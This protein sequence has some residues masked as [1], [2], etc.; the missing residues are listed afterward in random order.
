MPTSDRSLSRPA[1]VILVSSV[2]FTFISYWRTAAVVLCDL[3]STAYYIGGIVEQSIGQAAPWFILAVMCFSYAV[4]WVYIESCTLFVRGGVSRVVREALGPFASKIAVSVLTFD[5]VLT[6]PISGVSAG[7][8]VIGLGIAAVEYLRGGPL[9]A[10]TAAAWK[11]L[12]P[13]LIACAVTLYFYRQNLRGIRESSGK[14]LKI[15]AVTTVMGVLILSWCGITLAYRAAYPTE[16]APAPHLPTVAPRLTPRQNPATG[17]EEDPLGVLR[18]T[19]LADEVRSVGEQDG[20]SWLSLVGLFGVAI[21]FGH[22]ILAMSGEEVLAQVYREVE[23]PKLRNFKKAAFLVFVYSL[24]FTGLISFLAVMIIPD[25]DRVS[26]YGDNLI[27]GLAMNVV[28]WVPLRLALN[29]FVVG[30]GFLIL[31]GAVN[32]AIIGSNGVLNRVAEDGVMPDWFLKP[33]RKYGTTHRI[34]SLVVGL[35]LVIILASRGNVLLLGG[36]Y[37]FGVVWSFVFQAL[38]MVVLRFR[39]RRP[40]AYKVPLNVTIRGVEIPVGLLLILGALLVAALLNLF[41]KPVATVG[42]VLFTAVFFVTFWL[43]ERSSERARRSKRPEHLEQFNQQPSDEVTA[44]SLGLTKRYRKLVAIRS[45]RN[46][47]MLD[48]A[49]AEADPE[50]T[51]VVVLTAKLLPPGAAQPETVQLDVYERELL[52]AVVQKAELAGKEVKPL[53]VPTNNPLYALLRIAR[54]IQAHELIVGASNL[55]TADEQISQVAFYW[56]SLHG[57]AT[58]PLT[59]HIISRDRDVALDLGGGNRIP[60]IGERH[61]RSVAELRAAGVGVHRVLLLHDGSPACSDLFRTV[62][63]ALDPQ[64]ALGL[65]PVAAAGD[66]PFDQTQIQQDR[67]QARHLRRVVPVHEVQGDVGA[68]VVRLARE[69]GYDLI[70]VP[71][72]ADLPARPNRPLDERSAY[73]LQHAHCPVFLAGLPVVP[74]EVVDTP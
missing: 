43:S 25:A 3:A 32:T 22:S 37:A 20:P 28:G 59:V 39:D 74:H 56:I 15:M 38:S 61:A 41:T 62:L 49:L 8:Y 24:L 1:Q 52:T 40:R 31:A 63:T 21:A 35:Q 73:I 64:V 71:L 57:G 4:R 29:A 67:E 27:G 17:Q 30:V 66:E 2:M 65:M 60:K 55:Y 36:A 16:D 6:G 54:D 69:E 11:G 33:H 10:D 58:P 48:R 46:L 44:E 9:S 42:G 51:G 70:V 34:L 12:G 50:T 26:K 13:V 68:G 7:K 23:S 5:Y 72:P 14:A 53:V 45:P 18:S 19:R 47:F